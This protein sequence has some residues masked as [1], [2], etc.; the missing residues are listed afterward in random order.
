M[1]L[2]MLLIVTVCCDAI[3][4]IASAVP[5]LRNGI[6]HSVHIDMQNYGLCGLGDVRGE[7]IH[8]SLEIEL[9]KERWSHIRSTYQEENKYL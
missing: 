8:L 9:L 6:M 1:W 7:I 5:K 2:E 4:D 3:L